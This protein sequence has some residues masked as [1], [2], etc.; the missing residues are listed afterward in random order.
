MLVKK[1]R[2]SPSHLSCVAQLGLASQLELLRHG[3]EIPMTL[4][5][6]RFEEKCSQ[7]GKRDAHEA[8]IVM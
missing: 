2:L 5:L 7:T 6:L 3:K 1:I 4:A 8:Y